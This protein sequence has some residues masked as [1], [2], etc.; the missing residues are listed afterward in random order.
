M[1]AP[2]LSEVSGS[3]DTK[4]LPVL[5]VRW[6]YYYFRRSCAAVRRAL[7]ALNQHTDITSQ[8]ARTTAFQGK[9]AVIESR[10]ARDQFRGL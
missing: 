7:S 5:T 2:E 1:M 10:S 4:G 8:F 6:R 3:R 9:A